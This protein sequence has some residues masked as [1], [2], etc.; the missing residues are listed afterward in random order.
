[1]KLLQLELSAMVQHNMLMAG[2][3]VCHDKE[4]VAIKYRKRKTMNF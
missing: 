4:L 1:M 2:F 3:A